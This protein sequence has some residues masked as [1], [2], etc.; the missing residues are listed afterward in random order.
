MNTNKTKFVYASAVSAIISVVFVV[1]LTIGAE[2]S[3][4]LKDFLAGVMGHH[5]TTKSLF[6]LAIYIGGLV[7]IFLLPKE[8]NQTKVKKM[9]DVL[10]AVASAGVLV[11][12]LFFA[13]HDWGL[14]L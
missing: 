12:L 5:W 13:L 7:V 1:A 3:K 11:L 9:L 4:P 14:L 6:S 10:I 2:L 8:V